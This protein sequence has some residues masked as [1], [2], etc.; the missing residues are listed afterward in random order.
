MFLYFLYPL[1]DVFSIFNVFRYITF[2]AI[3]ASVTAFLLSLILFPILINELRKLSVV[4]STNRPHTEK[5]EGF[6]ANKKTTPTMGGVLILGSIVFSN[7]L[8]GNLQNPYM[9]LA[10]LVVTWYGAVG[11][12]DDLIKLRSKSSKGISGRVKLAGQLILGFAIGTYLYYDPNF[13]SLLYVPFLKKLQIPLG[14]LF[15][16]FAVIVLAGSSNALNLTDGMDGL[17]I[18]CTAFSAGA[19]TIFA[20]LAGRFDFAE[21]L[22]I[23]YSSLGGELTVFSAS[24]VGAAV[25]FLWYNS[26]PATIMMGDTGSL[27]LGGALGIVAILIK[28]ELVLLIVGGI[29]VWE[30]VSVMIQVASFKF[31][32]KRVFLMSPFHHHLQLKGW[33]ETKVTIRLWIIAFILALIG[34]GTIKL[35]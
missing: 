20:Y 32:K 13:S 21:Y 11:F 25:G 34:L 22:G 8:W 17:A 30:A 6:Y 28:Q 33:P 2:R 23:P 24:L 7:V 26:Y 12:V 16:P 18:G 31:F 35:R 4:N 3:G 1:K 29:F 27:S 9:L 15:I 14:L 5:I 10:L 19:L